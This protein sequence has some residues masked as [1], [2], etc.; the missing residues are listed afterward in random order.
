MFEALMATLADPF[1]LFRLLLVTLATWEMVGVV[2][3]LRSGYRRW[4]R[5][6]ERIG[7]RYHLHEL[8]G[9]TV[10]LQLLRLVTKPRGWEEMRILL[11]QAAAMVCG[12]L[13]WILE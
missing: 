11:A 4:Y 10:R 8:L 3:D 5:T 13:T 7:G 6:L 1:H 2:L 9:A 12:V